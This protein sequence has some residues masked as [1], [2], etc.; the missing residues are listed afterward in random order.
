MNNEKKKRA[1]ARKHLDDKRGQSNLRDEHLGRLALKSGDHE[2]VYPIKVTE[3]G[4]FVSH[5][6]P[7]HFKRKRSA[8]GDDK[9]HYV[10][11]NSEKSYLIEL[12][13]NFQL[14]SPGL[15]T[16]V[17]RGAGIGK[18]DIQ[19]SPKKRCFYRGKIRDLADSYVALST[20]YGLVQDNNNNFNQSS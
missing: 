18:R 2:L 15:V 8:F 12:Q 1:L 17:H 13:P 14:L 3:S 4:R 6:V 5:Y 7:H 11:S 10:L 9:L 19:Q 20:C 16:E